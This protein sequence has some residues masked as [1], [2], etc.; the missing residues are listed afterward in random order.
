MRE[1]RVE[2]DTHTHKSHSACNKQQPVYLLVESL[3]NY[4][5]CDHAC[6][7]RIKV[8]LMERGREAEIQGEG[9]EGWGTYRV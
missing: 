2:S 6:N 4:V 7:M 9:R 8:R 3:K 5:G 1:S